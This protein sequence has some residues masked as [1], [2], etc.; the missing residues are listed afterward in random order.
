MAYLDVPAGVFCS[1]DLD[2]SFF[3]GIFENL[4]SNVNSGYPFPFECPPNHVTEDR[5]LC[6]RCGKRSIQKRSQVLPDFGGLWAVH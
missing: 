5:L 4:M 6:F 2:L 1:F 3:V